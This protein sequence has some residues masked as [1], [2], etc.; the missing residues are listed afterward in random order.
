VGKTKPEAVDIVFID[1][2]KSDWAH[3]GELY[4]K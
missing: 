4:D 2:K 1:V 3:S